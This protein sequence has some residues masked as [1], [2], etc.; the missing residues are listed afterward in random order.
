MKIRIKPKAPKHIHRGYTLPVYGETLYNIQRQFVRL[1]MYS[2]Q[3]APDEAE[4]FASYDAIRVETE[5][6]Y[7]SEI[8]VAEIHIPISEKE[9][10]DMVVKYKAQLK[11]YNKWYE[12]NKDEIEEEVAL[13]EVQKRERETIKAQKE[14]DRLGKLLTKNHAKLKAM[15][16]PYDN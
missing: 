9:Y 16:I 11:S 13:R 8:L 12:E 4:D 1:L 15:G 7:D 14:V 2:H 10:G 5:W 6:D 3:Y